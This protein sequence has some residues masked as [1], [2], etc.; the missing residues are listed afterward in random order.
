MSGRFI[1]RIA[2]AESVL[3][4]ILFANKNFKYTCP[5]INFKLKKETFTAIDPTIPITKNE[6]EKDTI[7][8]TTVVAYQ[9]W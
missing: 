5:D 2:K 7:I 6:V 1:L 8:A 4:G 3:T 9:K